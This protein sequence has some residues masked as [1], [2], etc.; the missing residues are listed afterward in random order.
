[1]TTTTSRTACR[2]TKIYHISILLGETQWHN[3]WRGKATQAG[4][5]PEFAKGE[6]DHANYRV[7]AYMRIRGREGHSPWYAWWDQGGWNPFVPLHTKVKD[8]K[9][10]LAPCPR[11][12]ALAVMTS[13]NFWSMRGRGRSA[14]TLICQW[15]QVATKILQGHYETGRQNYSEL[16]SGFWVF[17]VHNQIYPP[18]WVPSNGTVPVG[19]P[20]M[21][22]HWMLRWKRNIREC[23]ACDVWASSALLEDEDCCWDRSEMNTESPAA[24]AAVILPNNNTAH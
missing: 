22:K 12:T 9:W 7:R 2:A 4:V 14:N 24:A 5:D 16:K 10:L 23:T 17:N 3:P 11:P 15:L 6:A 8:F 13:P 19:K 21:L 20:I 1:M 18:T